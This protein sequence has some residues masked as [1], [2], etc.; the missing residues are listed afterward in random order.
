MRCNYIHYMILDFITCS[1]H[2]ACNGR[3]Y[4]RLH[5]YYMQT[6]MLM[7][8]G[9][10]ARRPPS[11]VPES[12]VLRAESPPSAR[13]SGPGP[14]LQRRVPGPSRPGGTAGPCSLTDRPRPAAC[15]PAGRAR[16]TIRPG[17]TFRVPVTVWPGHTGTRRRKPMRRPACCDSKPDRRRRC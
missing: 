5:P 8:D 10:A 14:R 6:M 2:P 3:N 9:G 13:E 16:A 1:L 17:A 12:V 4:M 15:T 11:A 7:S